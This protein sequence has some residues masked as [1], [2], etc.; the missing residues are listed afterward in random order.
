[1]ENKSKNNSGFT[2]VELLG[3]PISVDSLHDSGLT[4]HPRIAM[5][6]S[7]SLGMMMLLVPMRSS[8]SIEPQM[9]N[10][11]LESEAME[12]MSI[13]SYQI[14]PKYLVV[15]TISNYPVHIIAVADWMRR[16]TQPIMANSL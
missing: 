4:L 11:Y 8:Y 6:I 5:T 1:M 2:I 16:I 15:E 10:G 14:Q 12:P 9:I 13:P 7:Y 3:I